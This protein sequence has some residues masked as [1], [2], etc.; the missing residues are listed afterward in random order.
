LKYF[1]EED[2]KREGGY[3]L[4]EFKKVW[5]EIHEEWDENQIVYVISFERVK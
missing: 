1:D 5:K 3:T 2:A 4:E